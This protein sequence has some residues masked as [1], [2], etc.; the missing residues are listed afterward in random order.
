M[1]LRTERL[2]LRRWRP[3]DR[4]PFARMNADPEVMRYLLRTLTREESDAFIARSDAEFDVR[5]YGRWAVEVPGEAPLIGFVGLSLAPFQPAPE[6][7]W[8][9]DR[10]YWGRGFATEAATAVLA[11][12]FGRLRLIEIMSW[13]VP[14]NSA[15]IRVMERLGMTRDP[16][17]DFEHPNLP[18]GHPLRHHV[19]YRISSK[20]GRVRA[21]AE[22]S[23]RTSRAPRSPRIKPPTR[24]RRT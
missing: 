24:R 1:E 6:I 10:P 22:G 8:R 5:G 16:A 12:G 17:G 3:S 2:I 11:D 7:G 4:E 15:S 13:T 21:A 23:S 18:E 20:T 14:A 19:L 9:L